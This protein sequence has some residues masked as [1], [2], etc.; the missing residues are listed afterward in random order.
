VKCSY[1]DGM[2]SS[3]TPGR[4]GRRA[5]A[6]GADLPNDD[7]AARARL[8]EAAE[9]CYAELGPSRT[10]MTHIA[11]RAGIHR[12]TLY[13]YFR[14][15]EEVLTASY[16]QAAQN[17]LDAARPCWVT[18]KPFLDQ[19]IDACLV[20]IAAARRQPMM[21]VLI[22]R[23]ELSYT[24]TVA[25]ASQAWRTQLHEAFGR[26]LAMAAAVG[27]IR[28]DVSPETL[29]QWVVRICIS[30]T[31]EPGRPE[32]GGDEGVLRRFLPRCLAP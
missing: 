29:A 14:N 6:W 16:L 28:T 3:Q 5:P 30:M 2:L 13:S 11:A 24:Q 7:A 10:K 19:L 15:R 1:D 26:R 32:D 9:Q 18:E 8:I 20:G 4:A 31:G 21:R 23:N 17:V 22:D 25:A 27:D 12:T